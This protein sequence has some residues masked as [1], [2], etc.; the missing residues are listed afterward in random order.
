MEIKI[1]ML[2]ELRAKT[3]AGVMDCKN[4][5]VESKGDLEQAVIHI[6]QQGLATVTKRA[7]KVTS[8]GLVESY[9]HFGGKIGVLAEINCETDFVAKTPD[10]QVFAHDIA[11]H[12]AASNPLYLKR[13][14]IPPE[15]LEKEKEI[16][17]AEAKGLGKPE[18]IVGKIVEGKTEKF[19]S[20]V[21]LIDQLFIKNTDL[22][23]G[24]LV[25]EM[26][27]KLKENVAI[28]RF[29]RYQ[30][31]RDLTPEADEKA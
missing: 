28:R 8:E 3:G 16:Y 23:I 20:E 9:V 18:K 24:Q 5:L 2:K 22:T 12:I 29:V 11:M 17:R 21:C 26:I 1:S 6:Y 7:K 30:L 13:D 31:G 4:A 15:V 10:F 27:A 19:F 25:N 14:D